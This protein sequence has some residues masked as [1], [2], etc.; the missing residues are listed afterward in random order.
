MD[1]TNEQVKR[2]TSE[3]QEALASIEIQHLKNRERLLDLART[4]RVQLK[5][6]CF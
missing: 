6:A 3:Q 2:L 1:L 4:Y 5:E